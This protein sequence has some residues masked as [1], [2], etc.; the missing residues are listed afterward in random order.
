M[1]Q[2]LSW[3][4]HG[5]LALKVSTAWFQ[6]EICRWDLLL[7]QETHLHPGQE[8][9]LP[10]PRGYG[11]VALARPESPH[12]SHQ[13]GGLL[14]VFCNSLAVEDITPPVETELM[15]LRV[16]G[17]CIVNVYL[18]PISSPWNPDPTRTPV[19]RLSELLLPHSVDARP[20]F[21]LIG[22]FNACVGQMEN[23]LACQSP[24]TNPPNER[25]MR[26]LELCR[27]LELEIVSGSSFQT[28]DSC[29]QFTSFQH[30]GSTVIDLVLAASALLDAGQLS[31]M[32]VYEPLPTW[33]DHAPLSVTL[34]GWHLPHPHTPLQ[35]LPSQ[36]APGPQLL[37]T[38][39]D[40]VLSMLLQTY[41]QPRGTA[42]D[43]YGVVRASDAP[44]SVWLAGVGPDFIPHAGAGIYVAQNS[45]L[46]CALRPPGEPSSLRATIFAL[47]VS[48]TIVPPSAALR[49]YTSQATLV[50]SVCYWAPRNA[51]SRWKV[52]DGD[53][54]LA[55]AHLIRARTGPVVFLRQPLVATLPAG[56]TDDN[57]ASA[58]QLAQCGATHTSPSQLDL[59]VPIAWPTLPAIGSPPPQYAHLSK[60]FTKVLPLK[61]PPREPVVRSSSPF[62]IGGLEIVSGPESTQLRQLRRSN[63]ARLVSSAL[64]HAFW[65][66]FHDFTSDKPR[67]ALVSAV[68][69]YDSFHRRMNPPAALLPTFDDLR[70]SLNHLW[71]MAMPGHTYD[72]TPQQ[73]FSLPFS[74]D[75]VDA[76]KAHVHGKGASSACGLDEVGYDEVL[77]IPSQQLCELFQHCIDGYSVPQAWLMAVIAAVKKPR[78]DAADPESYRTIGLESCLLKTLTLLIDRRL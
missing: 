36:A 78:K 72:S 32:T 5:N 47:A 54:L 20:A 41:A 75:E 23:T 44:I 26:L 16:A 10:L 49:I 43:I 70:Y 19:Q 9:Q 53:L 12:L 8:A 37:E 25:G 69:L 1:I 60:V 3:N 59:S 64:D 52:R 34:H 46:N 42:N 24:D 6:D 40:R 73:Y 57:F 58:F 39:V 61:A 2:L 63:L 18:P 66:A 33:S 11:C 30:N 48:L 38:Q 7:F 28:P 50:Q 29:T 17:I 67:P 77:D 14:A 35:T 68:Q 13:Q 62:D 4:V 51:E 74:V 71:A 45:S 27:D 56:S 65:K 21:L 55:T 15:L 31:S 76:V 22:D